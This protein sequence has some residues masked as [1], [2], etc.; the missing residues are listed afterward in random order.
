MLY[1]IPVLDEDDVDYCFQQCGK[2]I[3]EGIVLEGCTW[4]PCREDNCPI[5]N[6]VTEIIDVNYEWGKEKT[7]LRTI[8][9]NDYEIYR[10]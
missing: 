5:E 6:K 1:L 8:D 9:N 3:V 7:K 10:G 4:L 2:I